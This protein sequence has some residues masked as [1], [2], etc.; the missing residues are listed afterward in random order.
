MT[1]ARLPVS[2]CAEVIVTPSTSDAAVLA[3]CP[4][5]LETLRHSCL[6]RG[7]AAMGSSKAWGKGVV[8]VHINGDLANE[9][10]DVAFGII[11]ADRMGYTARFPNVMSSD[12]KS[13]NTEVRDRWLLPRGGMGH[14]TD[15]LCAAALCV[16]RCRRQSA[17]SG[18]RSTR[19]RTCSATS[20]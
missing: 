5:A 6:Q 2:P 17:P 7:E 9:L 8:D 20:W 13:A 18:P 10:F 4:K 3:T 15:R 1:H 11:L 19:C 12:D 16:D 14:S